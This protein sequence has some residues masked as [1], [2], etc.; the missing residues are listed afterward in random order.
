VKK[1]SDCWNVLKRREFE[2]LGLKFAIGDLHYKN[3]SDIFGRVAS[4]WKV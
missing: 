2:V 1:E 4:G 3:N